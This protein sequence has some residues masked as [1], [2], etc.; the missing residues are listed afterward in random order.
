[1][2]VLAK[3]NTAV[4]ALFATWPVPAACGANTVPRVAPFVPSVF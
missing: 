2:S 4:L 1:M 3:A